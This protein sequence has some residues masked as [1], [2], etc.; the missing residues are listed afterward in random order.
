MTPEHEPP[1]A[2]VHTTRLAGLD[3]DALAGLARALAR[4]LVAGDVVLLHG[5]MGAGKTTFTRALAEGLGVR[6]PDRVC[7]PTFA[8]R[9]EHAGQPRLVHVD[10]C[11]LVSLGV[12]D[13]APAAATA[14]FE[15]LGLDEWPSDDDRD[16]VLVV[17]WA[18]AWT[19]PP[20]ERLRV[21][22]EVDANAA[23]RRNAALDATGRLA[24]AL[25]RALEPI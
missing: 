13:D 3:E 12:D 9:A 22:L 6:R 14:A 16:A 23:D 21:V 7:S 2:A 8:L 11:R 15:A 20:R 4:H 18:Q 17:E 19:T 25:R 1:A 24:D 10:L 5:E